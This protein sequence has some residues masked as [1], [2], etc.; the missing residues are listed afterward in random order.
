MIESLYVP[1]R[2]I[3]VVVSLLPDSLHRKEAFSYAWV[4]IWWLFFSE[5]AQQMMASVQRKGES[6]ALAAWEEQ[7]ND[8]RKFRPITMVMEIVITSLL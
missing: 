6:G 3:L 1:F 4:Y 7:E 2:F 5:E 8:V